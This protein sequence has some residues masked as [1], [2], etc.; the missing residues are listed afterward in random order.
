MDYEAEYNNRRR[1]PEHVAI[2]ERW[3][4]DSAAY[5]SMAG[6]MAR[7]DLDQAYGPAERQQYDLFC[8]GT[9]RAP[10]VAYMHGG[11]WQWGDRTGHSRLANELNAH[12]VDVA[13]ASYSLCPTVSVIDIIVEIRMFLAALWA[14]TRT[15]PVV[16]GHSA[17]GHLAAAMVATDWGTVADVPEDLVRSGVAI[18]GLFDLEPLITTSMNDVLRLDRETARAASPQFWAPPR[19]ER[20]FIAVAG[21]LESSEFLRQSRDIVE[22][23][24]AAGLQTEYVES[25]GKNHYTVL[26][27][28]TQP[29][30]GLF[31]RVLTMA[32]QVDAG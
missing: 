11:Y 5:R 28:L 14:R 32:R 9:P 21:E 22:Y 10:L 19:R 6:D 8:S 30:S 26:D 25:I 15:H 4:A 27:E 3:R 20:E 18:S 2:S 17:G 1:V 13:L 29:T 12:G 24:S 23:W 16:V 7:A 31:A